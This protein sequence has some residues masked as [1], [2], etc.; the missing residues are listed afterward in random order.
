MTNPRPS[1]F[2]WWTW[3][4][5]LVLVGGGYAV[6]HDLAATGHPIPKIMWINMVLSGDIAIVIAMVCRWLPRRQ[7]LWGMILSAGGVTVLRIIFSG[8]FTGVAPLILLLPYLK[9]VGGG[10]A[11]LY[12]AAKLL[13]RPD[14]SPDDEHWWRA[15][16]V[17]AVADIVMGLD[18]TGIAIAAVTQGNVA[19]LV[20]ALAASIPWIVAYAA[21]V[22]G[23]LDRFPILIWPATGLLCWIVV[24]EIIA[25][26]PVV[27][28]YLTKPLGAEVAQMKLGLEVFGV[29]LV[30]VLGG[31]WRR[32]EN[33][34][35]VAA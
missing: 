27:E 11:L 19:L 20:I 33:G 8:F 30:L 1:R 16:C 4:G 23:L 29:V 5:I 22:M 26:D 2:R 35:R 31:L 6:V 3:I 28:R 7:R 24:H 13:G 21:I 17:V 18:S 14:D 34:R 25:N 15:V 9:I 10:V 32:K 12:I